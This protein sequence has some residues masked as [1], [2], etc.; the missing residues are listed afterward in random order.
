MLEQSNTTSQDFQ[1]EIVGG[2]LAVE[3][4][5]KDL[6]EFVKEILGNKGKNFTQEQIEMNYKYAMAFSNAFI[7]IHK[8]ERAR[9]LDE[10]T[11]K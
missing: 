11:Q 2:D 5:D 3:T 10:L 4:Q 8:K 1:Q 7:H 6:L 9:K